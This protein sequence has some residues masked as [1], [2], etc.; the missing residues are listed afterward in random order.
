[1][2]PD[3]RSGSLLKF[4]ELFVKRRGEF[5]YALTIHTALGV[6]ALNDKMD[7]NTKITQDINAK[8]DLMMKMFQQ[9]ANSEERDMMTQVQRRGGIKSCLKSD[10]LLK[11][12]EELEEAEH[13]DDLGGDG[14]LT[15]AKFQV[16]RRAADAPDF[17]KLKEDLNTD[18]EDAVKKNLEIF[19]RKF[20]I[21]KRQL[22]EEMDRIVR[23]EGDRII[24]AINSGPHENIVDPVSHLFTATVILTTHSI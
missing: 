7:D 6:D 17:D 22:L 15:R 20:E 19:S 3:C 9:S 5:E 18:P 23:R 10:R 4:V 16:G 12:L 8:M 2:F 11:E 13:S 24:S 21:Q 14:G 1:M